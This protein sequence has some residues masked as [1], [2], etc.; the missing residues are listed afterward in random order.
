MNMN[1]SVTHS[2]QECDAQPIAFGPIEGSPP[3]PTSD[4]EIMATLF[5][6]VAL[7]SILLDNILECTCWFL[8]VLVWYVKESNSYQ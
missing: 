5:L 8:Y 1:A 6:L 2:L 7:L 4:G 3:L